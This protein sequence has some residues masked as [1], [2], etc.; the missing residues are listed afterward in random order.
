VEAAVVPEAV[1]KRMVEEG[2]A[3]GK[4]RAIAV[5]AGTMTAAETKTTEIPASSGADRIVRDQS[6]RTS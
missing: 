5:T 3:K 2:R 4:A 1:A 6:A